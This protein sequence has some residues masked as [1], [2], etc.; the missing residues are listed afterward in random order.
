MV[1]ECELRQRYQGSVPADEYQ[2]RFPE[3]ADELRRRLSHVER[4]AS[5]AV[6]GMAA[7]NAQGWP[8]V[9]G[10]E[11]LA[12]IG[13]GGMGVV[14]KARETSLGRPVAPA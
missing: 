8:D 9:P 12:E 13:R 4:N 11:I 14:Y 5:T 10:Y 7:T 2:S 6:S 3:F 1:A